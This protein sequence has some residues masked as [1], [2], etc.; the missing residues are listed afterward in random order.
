MVW[1]NHRLWLFEKEPVK[2]KRENPQ[3]EVRDY[4][5]LLFSNLLFLSNKP[6]PSIPFGPSHSRLITTRR[7]CCRTGRF[8][9]FML[10]YMVPR[11]PFKRLCNDNVYCTTLERQAR[12]YA[13]IVTQF[14]WAY[15]SN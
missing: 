3:C 15:L 5:R 12:N 11:K 13:D 6:I 10:L 4:R 9:R 14:F 7:S 2:K 1:E 8:N